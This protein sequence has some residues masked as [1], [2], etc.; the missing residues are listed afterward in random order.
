MA[1]IKKATRI[2]VLTPGCANRH[3][4][5]PTHQDYCRTH[6]SSCMTLNSATL[7]QNTSI[8]APFLGPISRPVPQLRLG[9]FWLGLRCFLLVVLRKCLDWRGRLSSWITAWGMVRS[10]F[11]IR[12]SKRVC[13]GIRLDR[14]KVKTAL[15]PGSADISTNYVQDMTHK[16]PMV[17]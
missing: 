1:E 10:Q 15:D 12:E 17:S 4:E 11:L 5:V 6:H 2:S 7:H 3:Y 16:I 8:T 14:H 13:L 9:F